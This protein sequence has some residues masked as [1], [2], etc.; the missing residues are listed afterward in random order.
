MLGG[1]I[2]GREREL[3]SLRA[4]LA[5]SA[6]P[7]AVIVGPEGVGKTT[8]ARVIAAGGS[9]APG[10]WIQA[11]AAMTPVPFGALAPLLGEVDGHVAPAALLARAHAVPLPGPGRV[12][13]FDDA[14]LLDD[15][16][17]N[18]V[19]QFVARRAAPVLLTIR[20]DQVVPEAITRL[21]R[22]DHLARVEIAPLPPAGVNEL[23]AAMLD[24]PVDPDLS[25]TLIDVSG[26]NLIFLRELVNAG[27]DS[28][29]I[30][31]EH[32]WR[33]AGELTP[34]NRLTELLETRLRGLPAGHRKALD[35]LAVA[36]GLPAAMAERLVDTGV[37]ADLEDWSLIGLVAG[38]VA[39]AH[40]TYARVLR[41]ALGP[42]KARGLYR[43]L[44]DAAASMGPA[45]D[46]E[47]MQIT[48]WRLAAGIVPEPDELLATG[49]LARRAYA[50]DLAEDC[51]REL[52]ASGRSIDG[53]LLLADVMMTDGRAAE[54]EQLLLAVESA[55]T[56]DDDIVAVAE[57][58][59]RN[60]FHGLRDRDAAFAVT[61]E[62][63]RRVSAEPARDRLRAHLT[64]FEFFLGDLAA[65]IAAARP[66]VESGSAPPEAQ[67]A[68]AGALS[69]TGR[70]LQAFELGV[71]SSQPDERV[72]VV[73]EGI[74]DIGVA[75]ALVH[76]GRPREGL[77]LARRQHGQAV[78]VGFEYARSW[79][80]YAVATALLNLGKVEQARGWFEEAATALAAGRDDPRS[81]LPVA[82][83]LHCAALAGTADE[84]I[85]L[86]VKLDTLSMPT[87]GWFDAEAIR[88]RAWASLRTHERATAAAT[89]REAITG[90]RATHN[91]V[92]EA[93]L[94]HD[95]VRLDAA[96]GD[97]VDRLDDLTGLIDG[98]LIEI[99]AAHARALVAGDA[100][101]L[102][103]VGDRMASV[104]LDLLAAEVFAQAA[105]LVRRAGSARSATAFERRSAELADRCEGAS[106]PALR[107]AGDAAALTVREL[108]I[109][110]LAAA[111]RSSRQIA[112]QLFLSSRTVDNYLQRAYVKLGISRRTELAAALG[113][114]SPA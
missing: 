55:A 104:G 110:A 68:L 26:G 60:F 22:D 20:R 12:V 64:V 16:S 25:R 77:D 96:A 59:G 21:W 47:R 51:G 57:A 65:T 91:F 101:A 95:L 105:R 18:F 42:L 56:S 46:H 97:T 8:L 10:W 13:V 23:L 72:T 29:A 89:L 40:G 35:L 36:D 48:R 54:V 93:V 94:L 79:L 107:G 85:A 98:E 1:E 52:L 6:R 112:E 7:G 53:S 87:W 58:R 78:D 92:F 81:R 88:A 114:T 11:T 111:G 49:T 106:T 108:E 5:D 103:V 75:L 32:T 17:A 84:V 3:S 33:L 50:M 76:M 113:R 44:A 9:S 39:V 30:K 67:A 2:V 63:I 74:G 34:S 14:H 70:F 100:D 28:G 31:F 69:L 99:R 37:L 80:A 38:R 19:V 45:T 71:A 73:P 15:L 43:I 41:S 82:G 61:N 66:L 83:L 62:A 102:G 24:G 90:L 86:R 27:V 109:A 4:A